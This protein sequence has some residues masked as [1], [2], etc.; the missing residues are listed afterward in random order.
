MVRARTGFEAAFLGDGTVLA[1]G[2]HSACLPGPAEPGSETAERYDPVKDAWTVVQSLNKPRKSFA[3]V[4]LNDGGAMVVGGV[5][6]DDAAFS[7]TKVFDPAA[8]TWS[9]GPLL[10]RAVG[11]PPVATLADGRVLTL[12]PR[13]FGETGYAS[14]VEV[15]APGAPRWEVAAEVDV[16]VY[17]AVAMTDGRLLAEGSSFKSPPILSIYD[18][19]VDRW[20]TIEAPI[21]VVSIVR[22]RE[23][24]PTVAA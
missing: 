4:A 1:V 6:A 11:Q 10:A 15:L 20:A 2:D 5:N 13:S 18:P 9:D 16:Y 21:D 22:S 24:W 19:S 3:M 17:A 23:I 8:G 7:S 14:S 12:S